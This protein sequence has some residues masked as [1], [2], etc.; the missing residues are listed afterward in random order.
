MVLLFADLAPS[1]IQQACPISGGSGSIFLT[2]D[3]PTTDPGSITSYIIQHENGVSVDTNSVETS[4][5]VIEEPRRRIGGSPGQL[6]TDFGTLDYF[7]TYKFVVAANREGVFS[8]FSDP[9]YITTPP[10]GNHICL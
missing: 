2:W 8:E 5:L 7:T 6:S 9:I 10:T 4:F 3:P 1:N